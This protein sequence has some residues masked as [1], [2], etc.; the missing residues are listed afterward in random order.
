MCI[1]IS[2]FLEK[3]NF[4]KTKTPTLDSIKCGGGLQPLEKGA[5]HKLAYFV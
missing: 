3:N 2:V 5:G 1:S 4:T